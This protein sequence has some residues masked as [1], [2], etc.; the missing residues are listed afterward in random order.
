MKV[1]LVFNLGQAR[2]AEPVYLKSDAPTHLIIEVPQDYIEPSRDWYPEEFHQPT[3]E[4]PQRPPAKPGSL[5]E[6]INTLL[7][8]LA[9]TRPG[10]SIGDDHQLYLDAIEERYDEH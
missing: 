10:S 5:Q 6:D 8:P 7:G 1:E 2:L 4:I 3:H 9:L